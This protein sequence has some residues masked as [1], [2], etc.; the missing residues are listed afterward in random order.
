MILDYKRI[1]LFGELLFEK[2]RL[3]PPFQ[4][5]NPM[6]NEA[7]FLY[8]MEGEYTSMAEH[9]RLHVKTEEAVLMKCG[10]Y[11]GK[12]SGTS[13]DGEYQAVAV[14]FYPSVL[15]KVYDGQVP[16]FLKRASDIIHDEGHGKLKSDELIH[17]Y[18]DSIL[19]YFDNPHL[20]NEEIL[21]L[22]L[23][24][25]ILLLNQ[26]KNAP[27]IKAIL[28]NLFNPTTYSFRE[29]IHAHLYSDN[30]IPELASLTH[31]SVSSFKREFNRVFSTS[32]AAYIMNKK[33]ERAAELLSI[34]DSRLSDVAFD[35]GF[36]NLSHF[37][38]AFKKRFGVTP[39][40]YKKEYAG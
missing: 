37:S 8:V 30:S 36:K 4:V 24:E 26:T 5:A 18:I 32:P 29:V 27:H 7:C 40:L 17:R 15:L 14:H 28:G 6:P 38:K 2:V 13:S 16:Q 21:M 39:S 3:R 31:M 9:G 33:L 10:N 1:E 25:I 20:V 12:M 34:S 35:C 22:K 11:L 19:F 23:K